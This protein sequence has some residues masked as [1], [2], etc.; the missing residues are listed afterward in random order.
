MHATGQS[1]S[2]NAIRAGLAVSGASQV[3]TADE[4]RLIFERLDDAE[5]VE[6]AAEAIRRAPAIEYDD[7]VGELMDALDHRKTRPQGEN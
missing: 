3:L 4:A 2:I 7:A 5:D 1:R 6:A